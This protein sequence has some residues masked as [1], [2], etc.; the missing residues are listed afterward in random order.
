MYPVHSK[1][2]FNEQRGKVNSVGFSPGEFAKESWQRPPDYCGNKVP[3]SYSKALFDK[4]MILNEPKFT[5]HLVVLRMK[6]DNVSR[7]KKLS[8]YKYTL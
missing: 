5:H 7:E 2:R 4:Q 8:V 3:Q 1:E 6:K